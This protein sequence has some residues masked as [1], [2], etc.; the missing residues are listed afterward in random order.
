LINRVHAPKKPFMTKPAMMH[1]ISEMPDPAAYGA[2][3]WTKVAAVR[4]NNAAKSMY[5][6]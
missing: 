2:K 3:L 6:T 1:F 4:E 5:R